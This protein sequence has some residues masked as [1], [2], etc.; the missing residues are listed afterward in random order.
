MGLKCSTPLSLLLN[1]LKSKQDVQTSMGTPL[2]P[3]PNPH[4]NPESEVLSHNQP[5][6]ERNH[7]Q[8]TST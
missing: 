8:L 2:S 6:L 5:S 4:P 1:R 7:P 3:D